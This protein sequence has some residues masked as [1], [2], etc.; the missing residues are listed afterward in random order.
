MKGDLMNAINTVAIP[1]HAYIPDRQLL[2]EFG[3]NV[4]DE[5]AASISVREVR[6]LIDAAGPL[7]LRDIA[8]GL[9][10]P[11]RR[12]AARVR[13]MVGAGALSRDE[14]GRYRLRRSGAAR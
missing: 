4:P 9:A 1:Q 12:A 7:T 10:V 2:R 11:V 14:F 6:D 13:Q 3:L 8:C 5:V